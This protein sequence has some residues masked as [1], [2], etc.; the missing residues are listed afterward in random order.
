MAR[1]QNDS[2]AVA[3]RLRDPFQ[4]LFGRLF[5]DVLQEFY[6]PTD[7]SASPRTNICETDQAYELAFELPGIDE[8]NIQVDVQ[9]HMLTVTAERKEEHETQG[10]RWHR[11]EHRYGQFAR[12]ISLPQD[13]S[14]GGVEAV[15]KQ[16][17]LTVTVPK[18]P[19]SRPT[20]VQVKAN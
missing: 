5:G 14:S 12:T 16:G 17:V 3:P 7:S 11:V 1:N 19:E 13:A 10:K 2:V 9:D 18:R 4:N 6:G 20:R 8:K 15:F